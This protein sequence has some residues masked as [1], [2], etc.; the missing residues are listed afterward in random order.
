MKRIVLAA[1][2]FL[3]SNVS[4][5]LD[6]LSMSQITSDTQRWSKEIV[7]RAIINAGLHKEKIEAQTNGNDLVLSLQKAAAEQFRLGYLLAM[8]NVSYKEAREMHVALFTG[9]SINKAPGFGEQLIMDVKLLAIDAA[10][11]YYE[12]PGYFP[13]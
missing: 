13:K 6:G 5:N 7:D 1:A 10:Y 2:V 11:A 8:D 9:A 3:S 4:A 12:N